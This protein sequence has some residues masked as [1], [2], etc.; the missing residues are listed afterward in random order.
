MDVNGAN[1]YAPLR[2]SREHKDTNRE[3]R[4]SREVVETKLRSFQENI[5]IRLIVYIG[6]GRME[7]RVMGDGEHHVQEGTGGRR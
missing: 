4:V 6:R 2:Y 1:Q 5:L 7:G 3:T